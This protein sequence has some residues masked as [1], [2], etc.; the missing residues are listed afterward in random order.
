MKDRIDELTAVAYV[1]TKKLKDIKLAHS[2]AKYKISKY[3]KD[4]WL[5][6]QDV[7]SVNPRLSRMI[8]RSMKIHST[9]AVEST[10]PL[11]ECIKKE[12]LS[13]LKEA[14]VQLDANDLILLQ[15]YYWQGLTVREVGKEI[16]KSHVWVVFR[17]RAINDI[18]KSKMVR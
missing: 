3:I 18:I 8:Q 6:A 12:E 13:L 2:W 5:Q 4:T 10:T 16:N 7:E 9:L 17:L 15:L 1:N 14:L 11:D